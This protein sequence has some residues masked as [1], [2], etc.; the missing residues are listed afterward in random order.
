MKKSHIVM[1]AVAGTVVLLAACGG[2]SSSTT[3]AAPA[4]ETTAAASTEAAETTAAETTTAETSA[5]PASEAET[6]E[7][8]TTEAETK[9]AE[10]TE[11]GAEE[12]EAPKTG[13][14]GAR[15]GEIT[16]AE[17][18]SLTEGTPDTNE[19]WSIVDY[20]YANGD[21]SLGY[22]L[23]NVD[24]TLDYM[25]SGQITV[26]SY[27]IE[28]NQVKAEIGGE[29]Y[30]FELTEEDHLVTVPYDETLDLVRGVTCG[31]LTLGDPGDTQDPE[32]RWGGRDVSF[33]SEDATRTRVR[34]YDNEV[35][36]I[37][38]DEMEYY[39]WFYDAVI[40]GDG[41]GGYL[42][43]RN[44]TDWWLSYSGSDRDFLREYADLYVRDDFASLYGEIGDD[45]DVTC[46]ATNGKGDKKAEYSANFWNDTYDIQVHS[47]LWKRTYKKNGDI[48]YIVKTV[49]APFGE[50][51]RLDHL[52]NSTKVIGVRHT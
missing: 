25:S 30:I 15:S 42:V 12:A 28:G 51:S 22:L 52:L 29:E 11:A 20:W 3:T 8:E 38:P 49:Y 10:T 44:V 24:N 18:K 35:G 50:D 43:A 1:L 14:E 2:S 5:A 33:V 16:P 37:Y 4:A 21:T 7:A 40:V 41:S 19:L 23:F 26:G 13:S 45:N 39:D 36:V 32:N 31:G 48:A 9:S 27:E 6:K 47:E 17:G 46:K 34:D